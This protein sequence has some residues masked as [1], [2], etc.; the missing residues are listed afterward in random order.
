MGKLVLVLGGARSGK[1][2]FAERYCLAAAPC[3]AYIATAEILDQEMEERV[4]LHQARRQQRWLNYEAPYQAE[5]VWAQLPEEAGAVLFDCV[6]I[7]LANAMYGS[8]QEEG[9]AAARG[10]AALEKVIAAAQAREGLTVFVSNEVGCGIVP[11]TALGREYRDAAGWANQRLAAACEEVYYCLAGL[12]L[13]LK[14]LAQP[15]SPALA[16]KE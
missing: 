7:Y 14:Q 13:E 2:A 3:C 4:R 5:R 10:L 6:T 15:L 9:E 8:N 1:S 11:E 16:E 12:A